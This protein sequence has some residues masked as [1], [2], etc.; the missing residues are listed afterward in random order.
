MSSVSHTLTK[1]E[2]LDM[3]GIGDF[4]VHGGLSHAHIHVSISHTLLIHVSISTM[5]TRDCA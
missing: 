4:L 1:W 2:T 3:L 5:W